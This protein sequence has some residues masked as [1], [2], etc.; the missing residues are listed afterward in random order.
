VNLYEIMMK[1]R[2]V[3]G[4]EDRPVPPEILD[5][6]LDAANSAPTGGN[7][8]PWSI[9][10]V[11]EKEARANLADMV[12][13]QPWVANGP[14]SLVFCLDYYRVKRWASMFDVDFCGERAFCMFLIAYAD[15]M[16]AAQNAVIL[17]ESHRLGSVYIGTIQANMARAREYFGIPR[18]VLPVM[19][20][21]LG[22]PRRV[23]SHI[24]KLRTEAVVH[25][26]RYRVPD[27]EEISQ[28]L[29]EKYGAIDENLDTYFE[30]AYIEV[31]ERDRQKGDERA[32]RVKQ[33]M[34]DLAVK[35]NAAFLFQVRYPTDLMAEENEELFNTLRDAGF[36][37]SP[38]KGT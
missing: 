6:L 10:V 20:L 24:P 12:G 28:L 33:R 18:Y 21:T 4:F 38:V 19:V 25:R 9:I 11:E 5:Q 23:P 16:C 34:K 32:P 8:Q 13:G 14:V 29:E 3:R 37:F 36:D 31:V 17:A 1:R 22:Y 2:S 35:S 7:I 15:V 27:D 30:R 26:E